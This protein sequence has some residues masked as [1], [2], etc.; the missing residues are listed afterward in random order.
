MEGQTHGN[1]LILGWPLQ[2][3]NWKSKQVS[4][5]E[6]LEESIIPVS[7]Y[8]GLESSKKAAD[9]IKKQ[10]CEWMTTDWEW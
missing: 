9:K 2:G 6:D 3:A 5:Q 7:T 8:G 1:S 4:K 10:E